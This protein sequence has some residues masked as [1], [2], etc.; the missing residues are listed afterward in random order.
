MNDM[1]HGASPGAGAGGD[2]MANAMAN[3]GVAA[4][5]PG[6][7]PPGQ[8]GALPGGQPGG[9]ARNTLTPINRLKKRMDGYRGLDDARGQRYA[10]AYLPTHTGQQFNDM[11]MLQRRVESTKSKKGG[12]KKASAAKQNNSGAMQQQGMSPQQQQNQRAPG[13]SQSGP[14]GPG[15]PGGPPPYSAAS[16]A[17]ARLKRP[18]AMPDAA[19][20][21]DDKPRIKEETSAAPPAPKRMNLG[22]SGPA[23]PVIK[24]EAGE[25]AAAVKSEAPS[26]SAASTAMKQ[27]PKEEPPANNN[28]SSADDTLADFDLNDII[29]GDDL[30]DLKDLMDDLP[31][32]FIDNIAMIPDENTLPDLGGNLVNELSQQKAGQV[33]GVVSTERPAAVPTTGPP[34]ST[35]IP[36]SSAPN[37]PQPQQQQQLPRP[38]MPFHPP[39]PGNVLGDPRFMQGGQMRY[40]GEQ[41]LS[42]YPGANARMPMPPQGL[43]RN[44]GPPPGHLCPPPGPSG[45][46]GP[47]G[48]GPPVSGMHRAAFRNPM[49]PNLPTTPLPVSAAA[50]SSSGNFPLHN[51]QQQPPQQQQQRMPSVPCTTAPGPGPAPAPGPA[52]VPRPP[53]GPTRPPCPPAGPTTTTQQPPQRMPQMPMQQQPPQRPPQPSPN[54]SSV[55]APPPYVGNPSADHQVRMKAQQSRYRLGNPNVRSQQQPQQQPQPQ[56]SPQ[57]QQ[58]QNMPNQGMPP[59]QQQQQV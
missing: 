26:A 40:P 56:Q 33:P 29:D 8:P 11:K 18:L 3:G 51:P 49:P 55:G 39:P 16:A 44:P 25:G 59:Q 41:M 1:L 15:G 54:M 27:E 13:G 23:G 38:P 2:H 9:G 5:V 30:G 34:T 12:S 32:G 46:P 53:T 19:S 24:T 6:G 7:P 52:S 37:M 35:A 31:N 14:R 43:P 28:G 50:S 42:G 45:P 58:S 22:P 47:L 10:N 17:A 48:P 20:A 36:T 21:P 57:Q 4:M